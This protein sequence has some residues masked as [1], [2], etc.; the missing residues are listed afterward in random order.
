MRGKRLAGTGKIRFGLRD[1]LFMNTA[2]PS[3]EG[4]GRYLE[5]RQPWRALRTLLN[6]LFILALLAGIFQPLEGSGRALL[7]MAGIILGSAAVFIAATYLILSHAPMAPAREEVTPNAEVSTADE[8]DADMEDGAVDTAYVEDQIRPE[9]RPS[10]VP[11]DKGE[12]GS[13]PPSSADIP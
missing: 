3:A 4:D 11:Q 1:I 2:F 8:T 13:G 12:A 5:P 9:D 7:R 10:H 6:V